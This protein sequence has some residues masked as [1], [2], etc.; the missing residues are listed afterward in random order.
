MTKRLWNG[1]SRAAALGLSLIFAPALAQYPEK[2][3]KLV[4]PFAPGGGT[5][6]VGRMIAE[7]LGTALKQTIVVENKP[8]AGAMIGAGFVAKAPPDGY[9]LLMGT[10][11]ELTI[12]PNMTSSPLYDPVKD[13]VPVG[14][15][16]ASP[17]VLLAHP[18][19]APRNLAELTAYIKANPDKVTYGSGGTGTSPHMSGELLKT[20]GIPMTHIGY[21]G[22][23]P[24]LND[25]IAGHTPLMM[26][27]MAPSMPLIRGQRARAIAV[28]SLKRSVLLPDTPTVAEQGL[29]GYEAVTW[30]AILAP[31]ST[32]R[33]PVER[34]RHALDQ[35]LKSKEVIDRFE[36]MGIVPDEDHASSEAVQQRIHNEMTL[37]GRVIKQN[38]I[39]Q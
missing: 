16:G 36:A 2:P 14:M 9:T 17:N 34:L 31:A 5:D 26:S 20:M 21:K 13:F 10:N 24:A 32:P 6:V 33:D 39:G 18:S 27:T 22:T 1:L 30:Y 29:A 12:G 15:I 25:L 4:V 8:G 3:I 35:V 7:R 37:W 23:G 19:F 11:A 38:N 28:T